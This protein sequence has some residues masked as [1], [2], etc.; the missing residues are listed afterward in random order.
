R[1]V[2]AHD[3]VRQAPRVG[4]VDA[5]LGRSLFRD[6]RGPRLI[7]QAALD[8]PADVDE[9]LAHDHVVAACGRTW[10]VV[11]GLPDAG[12]VGFA[13]ERAGRGLTGLKARTTWHHCGQRGDKRELPDHDGI[14][15][16]ALWLARL[17]R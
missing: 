10:P 16:P 1:R 8:G 17:S 15:I 4:I 12:E 13:I 3:A 2:H 11:F 9:L 14:I 7:R 6:R 5:I